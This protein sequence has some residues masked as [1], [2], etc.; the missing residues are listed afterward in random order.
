MIAGQEIP[1]GISNYGIT[2][3]YQGK[4]YTVQMQPKIIDCVSLTGGD[5][6]GDSVYFGTKYKKNKD[7]WSQ[8]MIFAKND[9]EQKPSI[10]FS[11]EIVKKGYWHN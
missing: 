4:T 11:I 8:T 7:Y 1:F 5:Y 10:T 2:A 6:E 3:T 9:A